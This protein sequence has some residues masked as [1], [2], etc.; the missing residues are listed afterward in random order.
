[1]GAY[2]YRIS[3]FRLSEK[4]KPKVSLSFD[5]A[6]LQKPFLDILDDVVGNMVDQGEVDKRKSSF[7]TVDKKR[8]SNWGLITEASGGLFGSPARAVDVAS[9]KKTNDIGADE[10][11]LRGSRIVMILP[12][13]EDYGLIVSEVQSNASLLAPFVNQ[14]NLKLGHINFRIHLEKEIADGV[15][16]SS[17]LNRSDVG[18][19][20]IE[21][22]TKGSV[23]RTNF[24]FDDAA[25][26]SGVRMFVGV[27][28]GSKLGGRIVAAMKS[29]VGQGQQKLPLVGI[30][31]LKDYSDADFDEEKIVTVVDGQKRI[32]DVSHGW[33]RF[34]YR[35]DDNVRPSEENFLKAIET[36]SF[37]VLY[38]VGIQPHGQ[39]FPKSP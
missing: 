30:L 3:L 17:Y 2:G 20:G 21:L 16:W 7:F 15:A 28:S 4:G 1:M 39:W 24:D 11:V 29:L 37:S 5:D 12:P 31:G 14:L 23:D 26:V 10:A 27:E 38:E 34:V 35:I 13:S 6:R 8:K 19:N 18:I 25:G 32:L 22:V 33:P 36:T 9:G